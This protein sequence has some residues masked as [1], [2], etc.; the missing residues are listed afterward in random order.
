MCMESGHFELKDALVDTRSTWASIASRI[1]SASLLLMAWLASNT[2]ECTPYYMAV[3]GS[4]S[5]HGMSTN[6][7][8]KTLNKAGATLQAGDTLFIRGGTYDMAGG[9]GYQYFSLGHY[10]QGVGVKGTLTSPIVVSNYPGEIP[11]FINCNPSGSGVGPIAIDA[12]AWIKIFGLSIS[13]SRGKSIVFGAVTNCELA[14]CTVMNSYTGMFTSALDVGDRAKSNYIH[15]N[16][17]FHNYRPDVM[18]VADLVSIGT[19]WQ[20]PETNGCNWNVISSNSFYYGQ[21]AVLVAQGNWNLFIGNMYHNE[22]WMYWPDY[23]QLGGHRNVGVWADHCWFDG[24]QFLWA[25]QP[26]ANDGAT[27]IEVMGGGNVIRRCVSAW[28]ENWG[29][30]FYDKGVAQ[31][32]PHSSYVYHTTLA[33]NGLGQMRQ[34]NYATSTVKDLS[35]SKAAIGFNSATNTTIKNCIFAFNGNNRFFGGPS[36]YLSFRGT[37]YATNQ[38]FGV[39]FTNH[40]GG[41]PL[42]VRAGPDSKLDGDYHLR[43]GSPCIDAGGWL[44]TCV[45]NGSGTSLAV[46]DANY[47]FPGIVAA[48]TAFP[49]DTIQVQGQTVTATIMGISGNTIMLDRSLTWTNGQGVALAYSGSAPD[50]GAYEFEARADSIP[51]PS[52][53]RVTPGL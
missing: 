1:A 24:E 22:P 43:A 52:N 50:M 32:K 17:M 47:F 10:G 44:T 25:G 6:A 49:G 38:R 9:A 3:N 18:E 21:H 26:L 48:G 46:A 28:N 12:T 42:F 11:L 40:I 37:G 53:L 14:Y 35:G 13:N 23:Q 20:W 34:T 51:R 45:G 5:N 15:H 36:N 7:P 16:T 33:C 2:G 4:D 19:T 31:R 27:G 29:I 41:D 39:N 8:W 30:L